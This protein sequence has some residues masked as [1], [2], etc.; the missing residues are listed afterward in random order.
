MGLQRAR[1]HVFGEAPKQEM[2]AALHAT[3]GHRFQV[4]LARKMEQAMDDVSSQLGLPRGVKGLGMRDRIGDGDEQFPDKTALAG[5]L[6]E[7]D[8]VG[9]ALMLEKPLVDARHFADADQ[10]DGNVAIASKVV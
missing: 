7:G 1:R 6:V 10:V 4:V 3:S 9:G 8:D 5:S 2:F